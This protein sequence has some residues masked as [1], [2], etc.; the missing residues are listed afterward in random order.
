MKL[1]VLLQ[2]ASRHFAGSTISRHNLLF[3]EALAHFYFMQVF[4]E[5]ELAA[6]QGCH[7]AAE[8]RCAPAQKE[9]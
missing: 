6:G 1:F 5:R 2:R 3:Q 7:E 9:L 4:V 8:K